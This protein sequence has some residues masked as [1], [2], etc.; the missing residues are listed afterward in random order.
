MTEKQIED[1]ID[2]KIKS[3][4]IRVGFISGIFGTIFTFG[5]IHALW[6][7]KSQI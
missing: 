2:K 4:E 6:L 5:I 1:L 3:H 7:L